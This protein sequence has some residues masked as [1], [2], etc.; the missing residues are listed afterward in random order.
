MFSASKTAP[1]S[2][3]KTFLSPRVSNTPRTTDGRSL[4]G[5]PS[6]GFNVPAVPNSSDLS[7]TLLAFCAAADPP[8]ISAIV[9]IAIQ[10]HLGGVRGTIQSFIKRFAERQ[11][12][13][14]AGRLHL[15]KTERAAR[16]LQHE[17]H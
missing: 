13:C 2:V 6:V 1:P 17:P 5:I 9:A 3:T 16:S 11:A 8:N 15:Y 4:T 14:E 12:L 10:L 7:V